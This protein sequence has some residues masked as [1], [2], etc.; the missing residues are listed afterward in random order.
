MI[1][2]STVTEGLILAKY[3]LHK[4]ERFVGHHSNIWSD[5]CQET[6]NVQNV[7]DLL[8]TLADLPVC[9]VLTTFIPLFMFSSP[10]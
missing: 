4:N 3:E 2:V 6:Q 8:F 10:S 5:I 7:P 9:V 1:R